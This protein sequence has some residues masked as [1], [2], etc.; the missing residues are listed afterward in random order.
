MSTD[1][2]E[3]ERLQ[4]LRDAQITSRNPG[5]SK[6]PGYNWQQHAQRGHE[7]KFKHKAEQKPL[8]IAL[9]LLLPKRWQGA[10]IGTLV[11]AIPAIAGYLLLS[12]EMVML[13][14][15]PLIVSGVIGYGSG[16]VIE[17][18]KSDWD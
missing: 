10:V 11:G 16:L 1:N 8:L 3:R 7:L 15:V 14:V 4:R 2:S 17:P 18:E 5:Q 12:E 13:A 6:I 9:F